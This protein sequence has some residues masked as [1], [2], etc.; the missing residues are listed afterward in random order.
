MAWQCIGVILFVRM[1]QSSSHTPSRRSRL[2]ITQIVEAY[3]RLYALS[4][5]VEGGVTLNSLSVS[6]LTSPTVDI[7][8]GDDP[9]GLPRSWNLELD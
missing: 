2:T 3:T 9:D 5:A 7:F 6:D 4:P 8:P 1:E